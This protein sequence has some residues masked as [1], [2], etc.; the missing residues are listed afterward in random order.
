[1][2][3]LA[4]PWAVWG[5]GQPRYRVGSCFYLGSLW[6]TIVTDLYFWLNDLLPAWRVFVNCDST[7]IGTVLYQVGQQLQSPWGLGTAVLL[8]ASLLWLAQNVLRQ[9]T[10]D[11]AVF[12]GA[13]LFT[14]V[15]DLIFAAGVFMLTSE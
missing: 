13:V 9:R 6:G 10:V 8:T 2:E 12:A 14:L 7:S 5:L 15:T 3:G 11:R 4:L 1:M